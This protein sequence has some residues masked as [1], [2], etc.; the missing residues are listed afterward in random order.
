VWGKE[1]LVP[2]GWGEWRCLGGRFREDPV[3]LRDD[4]KKIWAFAVDFENRINAARV[5]PDASLE[6]AWQQL[7]GLVAGSPAC[8]YAS[9]TPV[10]VA[11]SPEGGVIMRRYREMW[12]EWTHIGLNGIEH[13]DVKSDGDI[14]T[15]L[16]QNR[17]GRVFV[18]QMQVK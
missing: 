4:D 8:A 7:D 2:N 11:I 12:G 3:A 18:R 1:H 13:V 5:L 6:S 15:I 17:A 10:L 16:A 9:G 14:I